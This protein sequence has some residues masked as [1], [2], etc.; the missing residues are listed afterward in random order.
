MPITIDYPP[1]LPDALHMRPE[2]FEQA[3]RFALAARLY[4]EGKVASG[5]AAQMAQMGRVQF[6]L[7]LPQHNQS[8]SNLSDEDLLQDLGQ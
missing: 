1:S 4:Q 2:E 3:A 6:L 7:M 5:L 8:M